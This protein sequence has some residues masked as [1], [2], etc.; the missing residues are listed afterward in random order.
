MRGGERE[1]IKNLLC[2]R[3]NAR[4]P[5]SLIYIPACYPYLTGEE[6]ER[7]AFTQGIAT[8]EGIK[9]FLKH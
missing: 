6:I 8:N 2:I 3:Y 7:L 1:N 5:E 4:L 9:L